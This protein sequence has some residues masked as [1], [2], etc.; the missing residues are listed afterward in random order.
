MSSAG[1]GKVWT[2]VKRRRD[3]AQPPS[4]LRC[5]SRRLFSTGETELNRSSS[6]PE[7]FNTGRIMASLAQYQQ[8]KVECFLFV[9]FNWANLPKTNICFYLLSFPASS[10]LYFCDILSFKL[11]IHPSVPC[12][13]QGWPEERWRSCWRSRGLVVWMEAGLEGGGT[14]GGPESP[15][16][17]RRQNVFA[18]SCEAPPS[19][20]HCGPS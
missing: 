3:A 9:G 20:S 18:S 4:P 5:S 15:G 14:S 2:Y 16:L 6:A 19:P 8:L 17:D 11:T 1:G 7:T 13:S 12:P 10:Q